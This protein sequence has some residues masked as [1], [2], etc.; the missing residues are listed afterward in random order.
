MS[1]YILLMVIFG[2]IAIV[3]VCFANKSNTEKRKLHSENLNLNV[4]L[5]SKKVECVS[6]ERIADDAKRTIAEMQIRNDGIM[7]QL[8]KSIGKNSLRLDLRIL[9]MKSLSKIP[10]I[11]RLRMRND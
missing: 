1:V 6:L 7:S 11:L 10:W 4:A 9:P 3:S 2:I 5:E 8:N